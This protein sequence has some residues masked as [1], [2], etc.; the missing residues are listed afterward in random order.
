MIINRDKSVILACDV[1]LFNLIDIVRDIDG[2][3][4]IG[5]YKIGFEL[6]LEQGLP[7]VVENVRQYTKKPL[8]YDHQKAGTDIPETGVKFAKLMKSSGIDAAILF[9]QSGPATQYAWTKALQDEGVG[10]IVGGEMTHPRYLTGDVSDSKV[11]EYSKIFESLGIQ[12]QLDG[13]IYDDSP[14]LMYLLAAKMGVSDFVMPGN[15]PDRISSYREVVENAGID[16]PVIY[17]PGLVAQGGEVSEGA[18]AAGKRFHA[19]VGRGIYNVDAKDYAKV[20]E[21]LTSQL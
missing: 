10:V 20:A 16:E 6:G 17:S 1:S 5:G 9:P 13:Y 11:V 8:I 15:K 2:V 4:G 7:R 21:E 19:I 18:K 14:E 3:E 12:E